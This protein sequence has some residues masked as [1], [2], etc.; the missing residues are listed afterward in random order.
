LELLEE[1]EAPAEGV[2]SLIQKK[3]EKETQI[4]NNTKEIERIKIEELDPYI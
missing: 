2:E 4:T 1:G 3:I